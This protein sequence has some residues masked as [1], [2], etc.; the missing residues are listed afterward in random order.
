MIVQKLTCYSFWGMDNLHFWSWGVVLTP[1][2]SV[3]YFISLFQKSIKRVLNF[4]LNFKNRTSYNFWRAR[5]PR[6]PVQRST[7]RFSPLPKKILDPPCYAH[8]TYKNS[9]SYQERSPHDA[10]IIC[11]M[12]F[13]YDMGMKDFIIILW[14][15]QIF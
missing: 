8:L 3:I 10:R 9:H 4:S 12:R 15:Y 1:P 14:K 13:N 6:S 5:P 2:A 11:M 7:T